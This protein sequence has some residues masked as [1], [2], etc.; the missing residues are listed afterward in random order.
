M[1]EA[2]PPRVLVL[3]CGALAREIKDVAVA[4]GWDHVDLECLPATLHNT[5]AEIPDAVEHRLRNAVDRYDRIMVGYADCGTGGRLTPIVERFGA[6]MLPGAHC[7]EFFAGRALFAALHEAELGTFY[8]TDFL[9]KHFDR[10]V[11]RTL[12]LDRHP[13][14]RDTYFGNYRKLVYLSQLDDAEL[15]AAAAAAAD[16]LQLEF[17][18]RPVGYGEMAIELKR[19]VE[20]AA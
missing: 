5:P 9:A 20:A 17:E 16:R 4:N 19:F 3:A 2:T 6:E 8:L 1:P 10:M 15:V 13:Q 7:Y 12:G 14:L 11:W 18:H